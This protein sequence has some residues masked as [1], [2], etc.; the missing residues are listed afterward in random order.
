MVV[1]NQT[2]ESLAGK[3][4]V[5]AICGEKDAVGMDHVPP[6]AIF[7]PPRPSDLITVPACDDCNGASSPTDEEFKVGIS[8]LV[9]VETEGNRRLWTE[10][11]LRTLESNRR[12]LRDIQSRIVEVDVH[13]Q[14]GIY[15]GQERAVMVAAAPIHEVVIR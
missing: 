15:L 3:G 10:G 9:G 7:P 11:P 13:S 8:L 4:I 6:K 12:L 2:R 1:K 14:H 5:C